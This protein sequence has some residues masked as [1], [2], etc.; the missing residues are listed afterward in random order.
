MNS[1]KTCVYLTVDV[2]CATERMSAG[3]IEAPLG[4]DV[5]VWGRFA[6]QREPLGIEFVMHELEAQRL[7]ATF[8]VEAMG[9]HHFGMSGLAEVCHTLRGRGHDVQLHL[10]PR[11]R[12]PDFLSRGEAPPSDDIADYTEDEQAA[13]LREAC[14]TLAGAGVPE[15][16]IQGY[17]AGNFGASNATWAAMRRAGLSVSSNYNPCYFSKNCRMRFEGAALGLFGTPEDGVWELP[18]TNF[19]DPRG[20]PRHLQIT[21]VSV[22]EVTDCLR[23]CR[24]LGVREVTL[25]MH[26]FEFFFVDDRERRR[27]HANRINRDRLRGVCRW[28][29]EHA[30]EFAVDT[31]GALARR[32]RAHEQAPRPIYARPPRVGSLRFAHR[33][34]EQ[35]AKRL[36]QRVS[37]A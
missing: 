34:A 7:R 29:Q 35:A 18:I 24:A 13:L 5:R 36:A 33:L 32:L 1:D 11:M 19:L 20:L 14:A 31:V 28:L 10:H 6:N 21:A 12:R 3:R 22:P 16:E 27:G 26:P 4:Y 17:R 15:A 30:D 37:F 25:V 8:F 2:E 9:A 23:R